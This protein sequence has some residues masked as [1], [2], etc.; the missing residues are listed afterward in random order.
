MNVLI[1]RNRALGSQQLIRDAHRGAHQPLAFWFSIAS[2]TQD[3]AA[4]MKPRVMLLSVFTA[5]VGLNI[6]PTHVDP[7]LATIAI[8]AIAGGAGAAGALNMWYDDATN[9]SRQGVA[10][11]GASLRTQPRR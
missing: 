2:R 9:S 8:V 7:I 3:F 1:P 4:L 10:A 5:F 11:A 6:A